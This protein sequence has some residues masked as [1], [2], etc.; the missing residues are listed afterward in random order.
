[1]SFEKLCIMATQMYSCVVVTA[2]KDGYTVA[3]ENCKVG[4]NPQ[5]SSPIMGC[6]ADICKAAD[7]FLAK[8]RGNN[9]IFNGECGVDTEYLIMQATP[10]ALNIP[11]GIPEGKT[12]FMDVLLL[13]NAAKQFPVCIKNDGKGGYTVFL[14]NCRIDNFTAPD[15]RPYGYSNKLNKAAKSLLKQIRGEKLVHDV[16]L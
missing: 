6:G 11:V 5:N 1:M 3:L 7:D 10:F 16:M 15:N 9:L 12:N 4:N 13:S 14:G 8:A 2:G